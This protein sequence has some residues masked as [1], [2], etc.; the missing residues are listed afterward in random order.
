MNENKKFKLTKENIYIVYL[1][2]QMVFININ[3]Y[4][5]MKEMDFNNELIQ[6]EFD[7]RCTTY[8]NLHESHRSNDWRS[9]YLDSDYTG[10]LEQ[11]FMNKYI[12]ESFDIMYYLIIDLKKDYH[13]CTKI[14]IKANDRIFEPVPINIFNVQFENED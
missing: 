4:R 12:I 6:R 5:D 8:L 13:N 9:C 11:P 3:I 10:I 2:Q 14:G 1:I 7:M